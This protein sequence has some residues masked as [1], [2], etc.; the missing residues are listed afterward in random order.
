MILQDENL[1]SLPSFSC[2]RFAANK[3]RLKENKE[4]KNNNN[5]NNNKTQTFSFEVSQNFDLRR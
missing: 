4:K 1:T 5:N 3:M 2:C